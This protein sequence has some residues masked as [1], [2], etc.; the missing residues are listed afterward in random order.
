M[1]PYLLLSV[2]GSV[3]SISSFFLAKEKSK[4]IHIAYALIL[5]AVTGVSMIAISNIKNELAIAKIKTSYYENASKEAG[6][7]L[8]S[9][10]NTYYNVGNNR[11]FILT[12][13]SFLEKQKDKFPETFD[14][15]K[16][17]VIDG[18]KITESASRENLQDIFDEQKRMEDGAMT[19]RSLLEGIKMNINDE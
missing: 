14:L 1:N 3:A 4:L 15:A 6:N 10:P 19:M 12:S 8:N 9:Y 7:I 16:A 2:I 5:T 18:L 17:L 11:G 13:F